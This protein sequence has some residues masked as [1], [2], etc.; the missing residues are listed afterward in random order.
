MLFSMKVEPIWEETANI[1]RVCNISRLRL[2]PIWM[3]RKH[4]LVTLT[5]SM[6]ARF[7]LCLPQRRMEGVYYILGTASVPKT[8]LAGLLR[9]TSRKTNGDSVGLF[10]NKITLPV[11]MNVQ[12]SAYGSFGVSP[13]VTYI[14]FGGIGSSP[15]L[16]ADSFRSSPL[17]SGG[18]WYYRFLLWDRIFLFPHVLRCAFEFTHTELWRNPDSASNCFVQYSL[19]DFAQCQNIL[20]ALFL[21]WQ[22]STFAAKLWWLF[23]EFNNIISLRFFVTL[24]DIVQLL[25]LLNILIDIYRFFLLI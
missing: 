1:F 4:V 24:C 20:L 8:Y 23:L 21:Q 9:D 6:V 22:T 13:L 14:L 16:F 5:I 19:T 17:S 25:T 3:C 11:S 10:G 2:S 18:I 7:S 12:I 15:F